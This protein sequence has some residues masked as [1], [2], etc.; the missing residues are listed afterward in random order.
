[1]GGGGGRGV[2]MINSVLYAG[3]CMKKKT[4][5]IYGAGRRGGGKGLINQFL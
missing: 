1:M 3:W 2:M 4:F 5:K